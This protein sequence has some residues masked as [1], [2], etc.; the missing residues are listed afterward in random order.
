MWDSGEREA[1]ATFREGDFSGLIRIAMKAKAIVAPCASAAG[2]DVVRWR[3]D[4]TFQAG[5]TRPGRASA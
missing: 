4:S 1:K 5:L 3:Y 2:Q